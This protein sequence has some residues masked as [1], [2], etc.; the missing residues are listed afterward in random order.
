LMS[1]S[2]TLAQNNVLVLRISVLVYFHRD[3]L[4]DVHDLRVIILEQLPP[5]STWSVASHIAHTI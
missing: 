2:I 3:S 1:L 4:L 5:S